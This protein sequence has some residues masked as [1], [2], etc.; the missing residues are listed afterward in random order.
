MGMAA[1][2]KHLLGAADVEKKRKE[3]E[4]AEKGRPRERW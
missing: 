1:L 4:E 2:G 3:R